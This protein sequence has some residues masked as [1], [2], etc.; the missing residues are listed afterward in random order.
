[1]YCSVFFRWQRGAISGVGLRPLGCWE[2]RLKFRQSHV[3][4]SLAVCC[5]VE[6]SASSWSLVQE[7][8]TGCGVSIILRVWMCP[9]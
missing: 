7:G 1:M 5:Q 9:R 2:C 8:P 6:V 3:C 4:L